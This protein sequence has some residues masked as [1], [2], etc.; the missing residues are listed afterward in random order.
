MSSALFSSLPVAG[1]TLAN[2]LVVAPMCQYSA[3]DGSASDWHM[4]HLGMLAN[5]GAGL[6]IVEAT[7]VERH[8]RITH[9]C[10]G[11]YSDANELALGH[12]IAAAKTYGKAKFGVQLAHAGRKASSQRP[13]EGGTFLRPNEDA[14]ATI[15]PSALPFGDGWHTPREMTEADMDRVRDAFVNSARRALR[16]GFDEIELHMAHGYLMHTFLSPISNKRTDQYGGSLENRMRFPLSVAQ[17][18]RAV[19][20]Q[21]VPLGARITGSDWQEGG[22][23]PDEA[24]ALAKALKTAGVDFVCVSSGGVAGGIHNPTG[25]GY[26]VPLAEAVKK[27]AGIKVRAV[28]LITTAEQAEDIVASG[29]ADLVAAARAFLDDPHFGWHA[30]RTLNADVAIPNQY[31]R[32]GPKFWS[33]TPKA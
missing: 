33:P 21:D 17:A 5:S 27:G 24:V 13:W 30:A 26:N 7:H 6:V 3:N 8:G 20:P 31:L 23:T 29:K 19:V 22:I 10:V 16:A 11:L 12:V 18:V 4:M 9:G 14:W 1:V 15:A 32:V 25:L 2:R 28:G